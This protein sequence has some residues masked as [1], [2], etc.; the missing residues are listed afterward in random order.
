MFGN[1]Q[2]ETST[3]RENI[4]FWRKVLDSQGSYLDWLCFFIILILDVYQVLWYS[5]RNYDFY[6]VYKILEESLS[7]SMGFT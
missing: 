3:F 1:N 5:D 7:A 4:K 2:I 6:E